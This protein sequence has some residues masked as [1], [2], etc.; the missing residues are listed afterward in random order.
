[1]HVSWQQLRSV[2]LA[3]AIEHADGERTLVSQTEW[4]EATRQAVEAARGRGVQRVGVADVVLDRAAA[5]VARAAGRDATV[6][7][8]QQPGASARWLARG[9]PLAALLLGLALDRIANAHRVD[10]LSPP[11]LAV[12]GWNIAIYALLLWRAWRRPGKERGLLAPLQHWVLR[13][14]LPGGRAARRGLAARIAAD[15]YA[16]WSALTLGR[17]AQ[18]AACV[19]HLCAAA[20]AAGIALSLLLRGLVVS[21]RFGWEST[22]LDAAQVHAIVGLL[23]AP[24]TLLFG[25][26]PFSLAD[27][28]ATQNFAGEG[29]AGS[30]W[31]WMY[32]GL[33]AL[34]VVLPRLLLA[35]WAGWRQARLARQCT[36]DVQGSG[37]DT[38]RQALPGDLALGL[39]C[40]APAQEQA[41]RTL[42]ALHADHGAVASAQGDRLRL[43]QPADAAAATPVDAVVAWGEGPAPQAPPAWRQAPVLALGSA[44]FGPSWVQDGAL[45]ER[46]AALLPALRHAL[47]RLGQAWQ[48]RNEALFTESLQA[49]AGHLHACAALVGA[50]QGAARYATLLQE[51]DTT[52]SDLHGHGAAALPTPMQLPPPASPTPPPQTRTGDGTALAMGTSAGAAAGA[53]AGAKVGAL[54]DV[55]T[56]GMTLGVGTALGALLGGTTA[57]ALRTLQKKGEKKDDTDELL[58]HMTEAACTRY[59]VLSHLGRVPAQQA[60]DLGARWHAEVT[61]TVAAHWPQLTAALQAPAPPADPLQPLLQTMLRGILQRSVARAA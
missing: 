47:A 37:F 1:M 36:L 9:L 53:A 34:V 17:F 2:T 25:L 11:L 50:G 10:L 28:A 4:D 45:F 12:L 57:W 41:L 6:A 31:V 38:L 14:Q 48:T 19:L 29:A 23:F 58:R 5:V 46:L 15:F 61:G 33:L 7:A 26:A 27:I 54:I 35:A 59:L 18:Q 20:W 30:R 39:L 56:G 42:L 16:R 22:F 3:Q 60:G 13:R 21:Y 44:E 43:V 52:L 8:L 49:L 32:V 51:L 24:L 55:G 40:A